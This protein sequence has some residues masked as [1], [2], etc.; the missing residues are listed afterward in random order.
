MDL[1]KAQGKL[2]DEALKALGFI[3]AYGNTYR[4][5]STR[6]EVR[7]SE[8]A[9]D[10]PREQLSTLANQIRVGYSKQVLGRTATATG[11][12]VKP[13]GVNAYVLQKR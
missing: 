5:G 6:I 1:G 9:S 11:W 13:V 8:I 12:A 4:K 7:G 3:K 2:L 10:L